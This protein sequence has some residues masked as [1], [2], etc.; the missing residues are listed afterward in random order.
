MN[1]LTCYISTQRDNS[2][3]YSFGRID[4]SCIS[5]LENI[6]FGNGR[7]GLS[8]NLTLLWAPNTKSGYFTLICGTGIVMRWYKK[9]RQRVSKWAADSMG[10]C[11]SGMDQGKTLRKSTKCLLSWKLCQPRHV[12]K[13]TRVASHLRQSRVTRS[14]DGS[15]KTRW[16]RTGRR[17]RLG[18]VAGRVDQGS[19][20]SIDGRMGTWRNPM[21]NHALRSN[22]KTLAPG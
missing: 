21:E 2:E 12:V 10:V 13:F 5:C 1:L 17:S 6:A 14:I 16:N 9:V 7:G 19:R 20:D 11:R 15:K 4:P 18:R 22:E 8:G 3:P